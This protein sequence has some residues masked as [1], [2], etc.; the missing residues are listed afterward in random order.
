MSSGSFPKTFGKFYFIPH[1]IFWKYKPEFLVE[2]KASKMSEIVLFWSEER[3]LNVPMVLFIII[4]KL[5]LPCFYFI[6][7]IN[8]C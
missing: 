4:L 7:S 3:Y 8:C 1:W 2:W 6:A 5:V